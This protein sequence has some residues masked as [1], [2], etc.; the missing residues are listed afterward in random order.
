PATE[1]VEM[2]DPNE[3]LGDLIEDEA[4]EEEAAVNELALSGPSY[5][6]LEN[7]TKENNDDGSYFYEDMTED[8]ITII[9]NICAANSQSDGQS[10][11]AYAEN[12][13]CAMV[14]NDAKIIDSKG[15]EKLSPELTYPTYRIHWESGSNEDS[16]QAAGV[17]VLTDNFTYYYGYECPLDY[18]EENEEF[19]ESELDEVKL[20]DLSELGAGSP[21]GASDAGEDSGDNAG[22]NAYGALYLDKVN[23]LSSEGLAD[24]FALEYIDEDEIPELIA[25]DSEGSFDHENAFIFTIYNGEVT[26]LASVIAGVDGGS[27]DFAQG[28]N[29]IHVSGSAAGMRDVFSQI[30]DGKLEEVFTAEASSMDDD[31][32]YSV[33]GKEVKEE[34]YYEQING[35]VEG[36]G[37]MT[38]IDYEGLY[39]INYKYE[40]GYGYFEQDSADNYSSL[41]EITKDL[42]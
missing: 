38:R 34:E 22:D 18:Y 25:S 42:K 4:E 12:F 36:Y 35:F 8:G 24:Q 13:V 15:D 39:E 6:G 19:Y 9:T 23:E 32:G 31:A 7:L 10:P 33:D 20:I 5:T 17:V 41:D 1:N 26:E 30:K 11:D 37:P 28:A 14:D 16:R 3:G 21:D 40:D 27:L 29:L 2:D